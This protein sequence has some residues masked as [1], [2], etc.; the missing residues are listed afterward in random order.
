MKTAWIHVVTAMLLSSGIFLGGCGGGG[1]SAGDSI[2]AKT[3]RWEAPSEYT[4]GTPLNVADDLD[5][6]EIY[7]NEDGNFSPADQPVAAVAASDAGS[8]RITTSFN[9]NYL[10]P[11]LSEGVQYYVSVRAVSKNYMKS[12]FSPSA[13]FSY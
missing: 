9:L 10:A 5:S 11:F 6:F 13:T 3:L 12:E 2:P 4:D 8:G 7:L 1:G